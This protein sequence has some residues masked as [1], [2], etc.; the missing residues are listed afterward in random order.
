MS[1]LLATGSAAGAVWL[2]MGPLPSRSGAMRAPILTVAVCVAAVSVGALRLGPRSLLLA[3]IA[4]AGAAAA[5]QLWTLR[6][7]RLAAGRTADEVLQVCEGLAS[8]LTAGQP[9]VTALQRGAEQWPPLIPAAESLA[10]GSD[11]AETLRTV[12]QRPGAGDL[13]MVAAAWSVAHHSGGS[14]ATGLRHVVRDLRAARVTRRVI[15]TELASARATARLLAALP[16]LALLLG[17]G[18]ADSWHFLFFTTLGNVCLA[19]GL[20]L[21]LAGLCWI[22]MLATKAE[23][24]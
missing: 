14:L 19:V 6:T 18:T 15:T 20:G 9:P 21:L 11:V 13:T 16:V 7:R 5:W 23:S 22:E 8:D 4:L 10:V 17:G 2:L 3:G 12:G 24:R 1:V